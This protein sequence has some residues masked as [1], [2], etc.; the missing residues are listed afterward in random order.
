MS[1]PSP[2]DTAVN[3]NLLLRFK[4]DSVDETSTLAQLLQTSSTLSEVLDISV[5][6][7]PGDHLRLMHQAIVDLPPE[8][9][10][11]ASSA[12]HT[13]G[14]FIGEWV[15]SP[16]IGCFCGCLQL[17]SDLPP[18]L[19]Y[20]GGQHTWLLV[21]TSCD[22]TCGLVVLGLPGVSGGCVHRCALLCHSGAGV[23]RLCVVC[24]R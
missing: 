9:A 3:H 12:V 19:A 20:A 10:R 6:T 18:R 13:G 17:A 21:F 1:T 14:D 16:G 24:R 2:P 15:S 11:L 4:D 23:L 7:L 8:V 5:R 22:F